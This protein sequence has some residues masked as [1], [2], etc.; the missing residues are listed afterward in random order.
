MTDYRI[1]KESCEELHKGLV[2]SRCGKPIQAIDTIDNSHHP[3]Y[4][5]GCLRCGYFDEGVDPRVYRVACILYDHY[6]LRPSSYDTA[7]QGQKSSLCSY[8]RQVEGAV[9]MDRTTQQKDNRRIT[10]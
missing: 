4:W 6:Q 8:V 2:C 7:E 10:T 9:E 1:T 3:T 5:A